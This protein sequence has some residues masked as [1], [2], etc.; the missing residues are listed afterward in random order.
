MQGAFGAGD[1]TVATC[2]NGALPRVTALLE[3][4]FSVLADE[5][6]QAA[7]SAEGVGPTG[8]GGGSGRNSGMSVELVTPPCVELHLI[9]L[10]PLEFSRK[11]NKT[12]GRWKNLLS[13]TSFF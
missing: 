8:A 10:P 7:A 3:H 13:Y 2:E 4:S 11:K 1:G 5:R 6:R 12:D 9:H